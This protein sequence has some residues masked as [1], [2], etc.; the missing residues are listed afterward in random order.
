MIRGKCIDELFKGRDP[1]K[2]IVIKATTGAPSADANAPIVYNS[3]D[4]DWYVYSSSA[5]DYIQMVDGA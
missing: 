3:Y 1:L 5:S 4:N 2:N